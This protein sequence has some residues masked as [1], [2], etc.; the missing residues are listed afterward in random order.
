MDIFIDD[1]GKK[2]FTG[3]ED[4]TNP[5]VFVRHQ[6]KRLC[7]RCMKES[8]NDKA[9][10][11]YCGRQFDDNKMECPSCHKFFDYLVGEDYNG[12]KRGCELCWKPPVRKE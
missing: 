1:K 7:D 10:C 2:V 12:G 5:P 3:R 4:P 11:D 9:V 8:D 6:N